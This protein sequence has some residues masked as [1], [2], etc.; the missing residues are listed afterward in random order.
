MIFVFML[1]ACSDSGT[2]ESA[3]PASMYQDE[4]T[5][6][7]EAKPIFL[8]G[9]K[10]ALDAAKGS[11]QLMQKHHEGQQKDLGGI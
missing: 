2:T 5:S 7:G 10:D 4:A 11:E 9:Y 8:Q 3:A 1:A 6:T